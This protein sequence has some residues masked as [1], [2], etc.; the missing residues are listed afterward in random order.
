VQVI[1]DYSAEW[2][3]PCKVIGPYFA[4]LAEKHTSLLFVNVDV[5]DNDTIAV[6]NGITAMP[7]FQV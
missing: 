2:C 4:E 1:I 7:T 5:D 6:E 3:G